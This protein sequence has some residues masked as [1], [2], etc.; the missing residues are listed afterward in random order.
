MTDGYRA[1]MLF[2]TLMD[3]IKWTASDTMDCKEKITA[4]INSLN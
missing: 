4:P 2:M 3:F 1:V